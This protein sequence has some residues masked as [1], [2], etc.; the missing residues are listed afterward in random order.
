MPFSTQTTR[1]LGRGD[2]M[3]LPRHKSFNLV[4]TGG[5]YLVIIL[6]FCC[7]RVMSTLEPCVPLCFARFSTTTYILMSGAAN[8]VPL[9]SSFFC[10]P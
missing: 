10:P 9:S 8:L 2:L 6:V 4:S 7:Y 3:N 1:Q 5:G